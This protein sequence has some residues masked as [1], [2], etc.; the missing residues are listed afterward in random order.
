M[1]NE[2][3]TAS[4]LARQLVTGMLGDPITTEGVAASAEQMCARLYGHLGRW[5]GLDG[6]DALVAR[7]LD[8]VR[9]R[10][11][12]LEPVRSRPRSTPHLDHL[13]ASVRGL[14]PAEVLEA[15]VAVLKGFIE[16]LGAAIGLELAQQLVQDAW[17]DEASRPTDPSGRPHEW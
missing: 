11:R 14:H 16:L 6:C 15:V 1:P 3:P 8:D 7:A 12:W 13:E 4:E 10:W 9:G 5:V 2:R 17:R